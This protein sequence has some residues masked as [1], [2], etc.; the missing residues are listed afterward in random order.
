MTSL[1][2][3]LLLTQVVLV[4][5]ARMMLVTLPTIHCC[6]GECETARLLLR[7]KVIRHV[8]DL[9]LGQFWIEVQGLLALLIRYRLLVARIFATS[10]NRILVICAVRVI[11][12]E[13]LSGLI[14]FVRKGLDIAVIKASCF[15]NLWLINMG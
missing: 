4:L 10:N 7:Q 1:I 5:I 2:Y 12:E 11:L 9:R 13:G 15:D 8:G 14:H 6:S 3:H